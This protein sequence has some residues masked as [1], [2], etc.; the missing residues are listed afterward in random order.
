MSGWVEG[1]RRLWRRYAPLPL[2]H[3]Y[4]RVRNRLGR[5]RVPGLEGRS[6]Y[7]TT[8]NTLA[9]SERWAKVFVAGYTDEERFQTTADHT[10]QILEAY[11]GVRPTDVVLEIGCGVGRVGKVLSAKCARWIGTDISA[12]MLE[13][14]RQRLAGLAN[15]ELVELRDVGLSE[16]A[17]AS[18]DL[19]YCTVVFIHL[20]EWDRYAYVKEAFRI[21]RPHGRC[22]FDNIDITSNHGWQVFTG[23]FEVPR[24]YRVA[25]SAMTSSG[26]ELRTYA[27]KAGFHDVRIHRWDDAWVGVTGV[28]PGA[29]SA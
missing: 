9:R 13:I 5:F 8:W 11:A 10:V 18:I 4:Y 19:V 28:K 27:T 21:L 17:D 20:F 29:A 15:V 16:I 12:Q 23:V 7:K 2:K 26:D 25:Q 3:A 24:E 6:D 1:P 14:A 22:F